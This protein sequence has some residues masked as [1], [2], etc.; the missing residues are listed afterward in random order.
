[1]S[2]HSE[3]Q[4]THVF[5]RLRSGL[6]PQEGIEMYA[7]G[8]ERQR[9]ELHRQFDLAESGE[10]AVKFLRGGYGCG[11]TL[12]ARLAVLDAYARNFAASFIV[13]SKNDLR[14]HKF[15]EVYR[16]V[17]SELG[18]AT[19]PRG[20]LGDILDRWIGAVE[21]NLVDA[22]ADDSAP[23][24]DTKVMKALEADL[25]TKTSGAAPDDFSRVV[26]TIFELK[27]NNE[28]AE[29]A[30]LI[31]WL[32][33][34]ANVGYSA[35]KRAGIKGDIKGDTA[36]SYLR[37]VLAVTKAA[38]YK[39]LLIVVDEAETILR[40]RS[41][42]RQSSLNAIRQIADSADTYPGL[43]W[44]FTGTPEFFDTRQGVA[45]LP[46]LDDR[47]RFRGDGEFVS[48][49]QPQIELKPF[50]ED[51]LRQVAQN[52][53]RIFP[54]EHRSRL[55]ERVDDEFIDQLVNEVTQGFKGDV[56]VV[57]RQFL[58]EFVDV[59]DKVH[60]FAEYSPKDD[61]KFKT[62]DLTPQEKH[63]IN[64]VEASPGDDLTPDEDNW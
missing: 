27:Q 4:A 51:R 21:D 58:R 42:S 32:S 25:A 49:R 47:I 52:L 62:R 59:M 20:A 63:A 23:D 26:Q 17:I 12:T 5:E 31:S 55:E 36:M 45:S 56:G 37:G 22:G 53:R 50:K 6:V 9:D 44:L 19:C 43:F 38:G 60:E 16:K 29:A 40:M 39:G 57:P 2:A 24:F 3:R 8:L 35:K 61:Y 64:P 41:D 54:T 46:P 48:V 11:K 13:V 7:V 30:S 14:L 28:V 34:S 15:D 18:T 10:G 33:G 1:M